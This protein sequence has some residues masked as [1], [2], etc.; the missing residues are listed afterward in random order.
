MNNSN[1]IQVKDL[2][3]VGI[4]TAIYFVVF[5]ATGML[6]YIPILMLA[7]PILCPLVAGIPFMLFLTKVN[8]FGMVSLM[9]IILS[10]LMFVTGHPWIIIVFGCLFGVLADVILKA[11]NYK[12]WNFIVL[13]YIMFSEWLLGAVFPMF[14]MRE[15][16]M[17]MTR[18]GYG[19]T[20]T[21]ALEAI[22]PSWVF[23]LMIVLVVVGA[24][25]GAY[26]GKKVLKKHFERAGVA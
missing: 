20:Y 2:I 19:D 26:A 1:R 7:L 16:Y 22:T 9:G 17:Q 3:N 21:D 10:I 12:K 8:K 13:G 23:Y 5:F 24:I 11:G 4:F 14:F 6:G 25:A 18:D 15:E